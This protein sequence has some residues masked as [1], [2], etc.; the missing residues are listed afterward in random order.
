MKF[1]HLLIL[2]S[3]L[4]VAGCSDKK[5]KQKHGHGHDHGSHAGHDHGDGSHKPTEATASP[6]SIDVPQA[7]RR[8]L[9][10]TFVKVEQRHVASTKRAPG[11]F[12]LL[13]KARR[14]YHTTLAGRVELLVDQY[15]RVKI[16]QPLYRVDSPQWRDMQQQL[17]QTAINIRKAHAQL[18]ALSK[19]AAAVVKHADQLQAQEK[20]WQQRVEQIEKLI[21][22]GSGAA[23][24]LA[25]ARAQLTATRTALAEVDEEKAELQQQQTELQGSI[26]G[27][28]QTMPLLYA[29]AMG[30]KSPQ[31]SA[32]RIDLAL[33]PAAAMLGV[34][35]KQLLKPVQAG[36]ETL[37]YWR[38]IDQVVFTAQE[39][40]V[41]EKLGVTNGAWVTASDLV[42]NIINPNQLRFRGIGLQSELD[43]MRDGMAVRI[44]PPRGGA[45][46]LQGSITGKLIIGLEADPMQRKIDLIVVPDNARLPDWVRRGVAAEMEVVLDTD[47]QAQLAIPT[48]SVIQD[49]LSKI[50][51][52]RDP[53]NPDK[54]IRTDAGL[55]ISD[56][57]WVVVKS[58]IAEGN[59]V[60]HHGVYE[61][62]LASGEGK[63][64]G[65][66]FHA[67]G[68]FH[69]EDHE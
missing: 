3:C 13:P 20:V 9:G 49:G 28:R 69:A 63:D 17:N 27:Y 12:E 45:R 57:R 46:A 61:L 21:K 26:S 39:A 50:L 62:M 23:S 33:A 44:V 40:G 1:T 4:I 19:R 65:G 2:T 53:Q 31:V 59:E 8:N 34:S 37:P 47:G 15:D 18:D 36:K 54:V 51:F 58:G 64:K 41:I 29:S 66:H 16:N 68:T 5:E 43:R 55:G 67:D 22:A 7:V 48:S 42:L 24:E 30:M 35:V 32:S 38:T 10:I 56:G 52:L 60:V 14:E 25:E 6:K 11:H